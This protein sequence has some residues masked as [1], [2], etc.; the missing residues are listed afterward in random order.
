MLM[1]AFTSFILRCQSERLT[2]LTSIY[3]LYG[4][5]QVKEIGS[6]LYLS[7][8]MAKVIYNDT[9]KVTLCNGYTKVGHKLT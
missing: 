1:H 4:L 9:V 7:M 2:K 3:Q 8:A 6:K 5:L